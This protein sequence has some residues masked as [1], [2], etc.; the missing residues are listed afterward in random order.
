[1]LLK[2]SD[3]PYYKVHLGN[4]FEAIAETLAVHHAFEVV[5]ILILPRTSPDAVGIVEEAIQTHCLPL[6]N[7]WFA[8]ASPEI[9]AGIL[10]TALRVEEGT[11][12]FSTPP[13]VS[14]ATPEA[15]QSGAEENNRDGNR[16]GHNKCVTFKASCTL[17]SYTGCRYSSGDSKRAH[18]EV[19]QDSG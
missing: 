5:P 2:R 18:T 17:R 13:Q 19:G 1:M 6:R 14:Q 15:T 4:D 9:A 12:L 7:T 10:L 8:T 11:P 16:G 3:A